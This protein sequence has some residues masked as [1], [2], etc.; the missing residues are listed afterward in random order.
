ML[1]LH[2]EQAETVRL[3]FDAVSRAIRTLAGR[4]TRA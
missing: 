2:Q 1:L 3:V 4:T